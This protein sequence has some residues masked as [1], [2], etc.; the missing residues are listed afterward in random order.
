MSSKEFGQRLANYYAKLSLNQG[1]NNTMLIMNL[2]NMISFIADN[3]D[4]MMKHTNFEK[5]FD[6]IF[7][8][9]NTFIDSYDENIILKNKLIEKINLIAEVYEL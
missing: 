4:M 5:H 7:N 3:K 2:I 1:D 9:L 6:S 8:N